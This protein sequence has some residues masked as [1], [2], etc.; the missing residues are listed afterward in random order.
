MSTTTDR[1]DPDL[2][3]G[4]DSAPKPQN[5]KYL[6]LSEEERAKG[7]VRPLR[8]TYQHVGERPKYPLRELT[9]DERQRYARFSYTHY[10]P[11]PDS[12]APQIGR[13]WT[14]SQLE[15][16]CGGVTTMGAAI[17]ETYARDPKF[18]GATYCCGCHMHRPVAEFVWIGTEERVGS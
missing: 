14:K 1:N 8:D 7:Y 3:H 5:T 9:E 12:E 2:G 13:Y 10:E 16:G 17:A 18:Y 6:V 11:Y 15:A 4:A